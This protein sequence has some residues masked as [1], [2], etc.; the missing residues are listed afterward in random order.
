MPTYEYR[1]PTHGAL[2]V[3]KPMGEA[4]R[5]EVCPVCRGAFLRGEVTAE[6]PPLRRVY[7]AQALIV[8]PSGWHLRPGERGY[9]D[10]RRE[11]EL[12]EVRAGSLMPRYFRPD[13]S[14]TAREAPPPVELPTS[15]LREIHNLG[16]MVD[17]EIRASADIPEL[18]REGV[19]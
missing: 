19:I 17:R 18:W 9:G 1:C 7:A 3:E 4:G 11:L 14:L 2:L 13:E 10:F 16:A 8:R 12:G 5:A 6:P 15:S